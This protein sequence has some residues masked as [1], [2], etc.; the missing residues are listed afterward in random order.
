MAA[1]RENSDNVCKAVLVRMISHPKVPTILDATGSETRGLP[2]NAAVSVA[3]TVCGVGHG[4]NIVV[5]TE[6]CGSVESIVSGK[7]VGVD[8]KMPVGSVGAGDSIVIRGLFSSC[9]HMPG[10]NS[11][12]GS[13]AEEVMK[14]SNG[15]VEGALIIDVA[16]VSG[17]ESDALILSVHVTSC[18]SN[19][20]TLR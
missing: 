1:V 12:K 2:K 7:V 5:T 18:A 16:A 10:V 20:G 8:L 4:E 15:A 9:N 13:S 6:M 3:G 19:E 11:G 17:D 14:A